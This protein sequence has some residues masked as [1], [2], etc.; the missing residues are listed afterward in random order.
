MRKLW[1]LPCLTAA[2]TA[3][4]ISGKWVGAVEVEDPSDGATISTEVR[5][6]FQQQDGKISGKVGRQEDQESESIQNARLDGQRL[7]FEVTSTEMSG[8]FKFALTLEGDRLEGEMSG[9]MDGNPIT[10]KVKLKRPAA[11]AP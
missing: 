4:D 8:L 5:A 9:S 6:E 2:L 7:T 3:A 11:K 1:L 10:G